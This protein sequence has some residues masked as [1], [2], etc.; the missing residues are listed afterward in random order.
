MRDMDEDVRKRLGYRA[1]ARMQR[2]TKE[3]AIK[4]AYAEGL[5]DGGALIR[6]IAI[7]RINTGSSLSFI[8]DVGVRHGT[9]KQTK[10]TKA[11]GANVN[12]PWYWF[13]HEFGFT[14][15]GGRHHAG[16]HFMTKAFERRKSDGLAMMG[17]TMW[18]GIKKWEK[19]K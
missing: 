15:R 2:A 16:K 1:V 7:A 6:N 3:D 5:L 17:E 19:S 12:D 11:A 14:D 8:Y 4:N 18:K 10:Q 13:L 9:K